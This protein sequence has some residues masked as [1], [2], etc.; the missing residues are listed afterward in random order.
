MRSLTLSVGTPRPVVAA[1]VVVLVIVGLV[2][3]LHLTIDRAPVPIPASTQLARTTTTA[4]TSPEPAPSSAAA[5]IGSPPRAT[6]VPT[7]AAEGWSAPKSATVN[8]RLPVIHHPT[9]AGQVPRVG[10]DTDPDGR[11][12]PW[13]QRDDDRDDDDEDDDTHDRDDGQTRQRM[14][15]SI[16][17]RYGLARENCERAASK[18]GD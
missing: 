18:Y 17:D 6:E 1:A 16:C 10:A 2:T 12:R 13:H 5:A 3:A 9:S 11:A 7:P 15:D 4:A 8:P 14:A